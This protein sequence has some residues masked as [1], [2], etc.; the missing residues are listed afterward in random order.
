MPNRLRLHDPQAILLLVVGIPTE[1]KEKEGGK[2][3]DSDG[4]ASERTRTRLGVQ[5]ALL[6]R[7][8]NY[9]KTPA[10]AG[11]TT[12]QWRYSAVLRVK[13]GTWLNRR[14]YNRLVP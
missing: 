11:E 12:D 10:T 5:Q 1:E 4:W 7:L 8:V 2:A 13:S 6:T 9:H 3:S 14:R